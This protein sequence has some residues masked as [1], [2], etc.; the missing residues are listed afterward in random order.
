MVDVDKAVVARIIKNGEHFEALVDCE[1]ALALKQGKSISINDVIASDKIFS[2]SKKGL[3]ASENKLQEVFSTMDHAKIAE[4][5]ILEGEVQLTAT[6]REKLRQQ[7]YKRILDYIHRNGIDPRTKQ[8]HPTTRIELAFEEAKVKV[9]YNKPEQEQINEIV[10]K[11][12]PILPISFESIKAKIVVPAK[13][14]GK[15]YSIVQ[16]YSL[17]KTDNWGKDGSWLGEVEVQSGSRD[18]LVDELNHLSHGE[19]TIEIIK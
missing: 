9:D 12:K 18:K 14:A 16:R 19:V 7:K 13:Y 11:L 3:V 2:D 15:A 17:I 5:I 8:P 10:K 1:N 6:Y 4:K